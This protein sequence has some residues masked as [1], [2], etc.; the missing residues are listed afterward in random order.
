MRSHAF[1]SLLFDMRECGDG[2]GGMRVLVACEYSGRVREAF[3]ALGHDAWSCDLLPSEDESPFH[4]QGDVSE[5]FDGIAEG[6]PGGPQPRGQP[7]AAAAGHGGRV[8]GGAAS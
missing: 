5:W 2:E 8:R 4:I 7:G 6:Y 3:R 1:S